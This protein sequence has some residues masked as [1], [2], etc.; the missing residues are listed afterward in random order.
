M[1]FDHFDL[2]AS[3]Y[4]RK[5]IFSTPAL[6]LD[7]LALQ[8]DSLMLDAG[9]GTGRVAE[10]LNNMVHDVVVAD[11]SRGMLL[12]ATDKGLAATCAPAEHLPFASNTFDRII[13]VDALH[14][15]FDQRQTVTELFRVLAPGGRVVII[16][17]DIHKFVV[18]VIAIAEKLL[19][20]RSHFLPA[21]NIAALFVNQNT[22]V[23]IVPF[24][25]NVWIC[26]EKGREI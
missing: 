11:L 15:V 21:E 23:R 5:A 14:H 4:N 26:A 20:M 13:M 9:G 25:L 17:P 3:F 2:I 8:P 22:Q 16:E 7:L 19:F 1:P 18:K 24:E 6:L 12:H 10:A